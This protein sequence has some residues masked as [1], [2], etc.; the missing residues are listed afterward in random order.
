MREKDR[1]HGDA[2][3]QGKICMRK[4]WESGRAQSMKWETVVVDAAIR[5]FCENRSVEPNLLQT[6]HSCR[7][8]RN[9][10]LRAEIKA[11]LDAAARIANLAER[12]SPLKAQSS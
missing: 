2:A 5:A 7:L 11:A 10:F 6:P 8:R 4:G 12:C 1:E 3:L 9:N